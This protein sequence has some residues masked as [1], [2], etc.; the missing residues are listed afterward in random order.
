MR[1]RGNK[2]PA[3]FACTDPV[4]RLA[5]SQKTQYILLDMAGFEKSDVC[6]FESLRANGSWPEFRGFF[7]S[8]RAMH[9][10]FVVRNSK[11]TVWFLMDRLVNP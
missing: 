9:K 2:F 8:W 1:P 5:I 11:K 4:P 3:R 7:R 6:I 10:P